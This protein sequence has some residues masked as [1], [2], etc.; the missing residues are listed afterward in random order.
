MVKF[1]NEEVENPRLKK[2]NES[3]LKLLYKYGIRKLTVEDICKDSGVSKMT[4]YK[5][6]EN[7]QDVVLYTLGMLM[8][9]SVKVFR[10][11]MAENISFEEKVEKTIDSKMK[12]ASS[13]SEDFVSDL[14][15]YGGPEVMD[16]IQKL[17]ADANKAVFEEYSKAQQDGLIRKDM[18]LQ[19]MILFMNHMEEMAKDPKFLSLFKTPAEMIGE[20]VHFF[21]YGIM[22]RPVHHETKQ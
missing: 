20:L 10:Q 1:G 21:F 14:L 8:E 7:K 3:A 6:F 18:N 15:Q 5:Y 4:F 19:F 22:P 9:N 17:V 13:V 2:L 11:I 12:Y 16:L